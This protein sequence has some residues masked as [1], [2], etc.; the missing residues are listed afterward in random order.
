[1]NG[2]GSAPAL[3]GRPSRS[4]GLFPFLNCRSGRATWLRERQ[5]KKKE[6]G[7]PHGG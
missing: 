6:I 3:D 2:L 7:T 5:F 4:N 1:M